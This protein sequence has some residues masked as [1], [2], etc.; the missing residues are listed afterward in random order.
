VFGWKD[1]A[2]QKIMDEACYVNCKSMRTQSIEQMN[3]CSVPGFVNEDVGDTD[4][5]SAVFPR[6]RRLTL[7]PGLASIPGQPM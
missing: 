2:L 5:K 3:S 7:E 1:D 6:V 4:C